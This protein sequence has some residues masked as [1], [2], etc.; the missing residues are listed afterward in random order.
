MDASL[1]QGVNAVA[2]SGTF[3]AHRVAM[4]LGLEPKMPVGDDLFFGMLAQV[5]KR[6]G[7]K[8]M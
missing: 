6:L 3:C 8:S 5:P 2:L 7:E 1:V 4:D